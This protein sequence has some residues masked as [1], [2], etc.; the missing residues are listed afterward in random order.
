M[1]QVR[2]PA[3]IRGAIAALPASKIREVSR[4]GMGQANVIPLWFGESDEATPSF[5]RDAAA[6]SLAAGDTFY[7]ANRG[8]PELREAIAA[9]MRRLYGVPIHMDRIT[10][11]ASGMNAIMIALQCLV[12]AGDNVVLVGPMW[13]NA[14]EV[15][16][17]MGGEPRFVDLQTAPAGWQL[18]L[19]RLFAACDGR[20]R[21]IIVNSP[22]NPTGWMMP[23]AQQTEILAF[24]RARGIWL[25]A[26]EVY[27]RI[28][29]D[30]PFAPSFL[31]HAGP[32]D[33]VIVVNSFSKTWSMTGWRLG[34]FTA[35]QALGEVLEKM[36]EYNIAAPP[37][38]V[39]RGGVAAIEQ[40]ESYVHH[41][42]ERFGRA[43]EMVQ[44]RLGA[45]R[46]V[47]LTR[48]AAAFYAFFA[49]DGMR[50]SLE[51]CKTILA[52][53]G[54]GLAPGIAFGPAGEG[55]IRLCFASSIA[56]LDEALD[57]LKPVLD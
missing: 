35:P 50:D 42:V 19:E 32:D 31:E 4:I 24:C 3:A 29:Y 52:Q 18:D 28:V 57:R 39:Q 30:R 49:V 34:W 46:R 38:F 47:Q 22:G 40:G 43:R 8:A 17:I 44:Q 1:T 56:R 7:M 37:G 13:P 55:W 54:V 27:A 11:T 15:V 51:Y 5:I 16:R 53:T 36:N 26:D 25:I 10:V 21:A 20:T 6:A 48:P 23:S 2:N 45:Y 12:G 41:L 14:R 9:Y 33:P